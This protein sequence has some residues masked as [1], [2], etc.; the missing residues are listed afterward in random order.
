MKCTLFR[1]VLYAIKQV[2][3]AELTMALKAHGGVYEFEDESLVV[4]IDDGHGAQDVVVLLV[5][6]YYHGGIVLHACEREVYAWNKDVTK[7]F[8][9]SACLH[10][11]TNHVQ[12]TDGVNDVSFFTKEQKIAEL[13][14]KIKKI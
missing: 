10:Y 6:L 14:T 11:I 1:E 4:T 8:G 9:V 7:K 2:C 13:I 3:L 12:V 5:T